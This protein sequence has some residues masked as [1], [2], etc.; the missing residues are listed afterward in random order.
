[1]DRRRPHSHDRP[2]ADRVHRRLGRIIQ[3]RTQ[4]AARPSKEAIVIIKYAKRL[5]KIPEYP[6]AELDRKKAALIEK[7]ADVISLAVGDPDIPTPKKIIETLA[8]EAANPANHQYPSYEGM[9]IFREAVARWY[10]KRFGVTLDPKKEV[11]SLI[12]SKEGIAHIYPAFVQAGDI[13]LVPSPGYPVYNAGTILAEGT[14]LVMP[15]LSRNNF[16]PDFDAIPAE[17]LDKARIMFVN[18]PNNPTAAT[19]SLDF[20]KRAVAFAREHDIVLCSDNAY[21][22]ITYDGYKAP[23]ILEVEGAKDVAIEFHSLSK[24]YCMTGWRCGFAVGNADILAGLAQ[25]KTNVDSGLFQAI[26]HAGITALDEVSDDMQEMLQT[27]TERRNLVVDSLNSMG[28]KLEKPKGTF[29]V[30]APVPEGMDCVQFVARVLEEAHVAV[31]PGTA[32]GAEDEVKRFFRISFT[33]NSKR[34][35]EAMER[36]GKLKF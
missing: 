5:K 22:E 19:A 16:L 21:S 36:I 24:S 23:S 13:S 9:L 4:R 27:F 10:H 20:Y 6:F 25:V 33:L 30:W 18:Y 29:Y 35:E 26:Q 1:M 14:P 11:V 2:R 15:L 12:G 8:R 31:T 28:W 32:F 7:G 3:T 34:L 17:A